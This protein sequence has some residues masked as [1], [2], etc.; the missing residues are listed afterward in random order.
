M[1]GAG[2]NELQVHFD[3]AQPRYR[4]IAFAFS[5]TNYHYR[6]VRQITGYRA[7]L[8]PWA[9]VGSCL[10]PQKRQQ[11]P[12]PADVVTTNARR[13]Q[14]W[15]FSGSA[16]AAF[17]YCRPTIPKKPFIFCRRSF[18]LARVESAL[19]ADIVDG[20]DA[21]LRHDSYHARH[22]IDARDD[23]VDASARRLHYRIAA[24]RMQASNGRSSLSR[25]AISPTIPLERRL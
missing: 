12:L 3:F 16:V 25:Q 1:R 13:L 4:I 23:A 24:E 17:R 22:A 9:A 21:G 15:P 10:S 20:L 18:L 8:P 11:Q 2:F 7:C 5:S 19:T 6:A 14:G